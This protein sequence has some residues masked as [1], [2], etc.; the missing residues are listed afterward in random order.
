MPMNSY[1]LDSLIRDRLSDARDR[2][3]KHALL[4][5]VKRAP[6]TRPAWVDVL[7]AFALGGAQAVERGR[8]TPAGTEATATHGV[9]GPR[10]VGWRGRLRVDELFMTVMVVAFLATG[11]GPSTMADFPST[12][13]RR[14][15]GASMVAE[16][17]FP[18]H[19]GAYELLFA[20][21]PGTPWQARRAALLVDLAGGQ[22]LARGFVEAGRAGEAPMVYTAGGWARQREIGGERLTVFEL[23]LNYLVGPD[24]PRVALDSGLLAPLAIRVV[25]HEG[26]DD[27]TLTRRR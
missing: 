1:L 21:T 15:Q 4:H 2:A 17:S 26:S 18:V 11:C 22:G 9:L 13:G 12:G 6:R 25:V 14:V 24:T 20:T 5:S 19:L 7:K 16:G 8:R 27:V 3:A 23:Q 10:H